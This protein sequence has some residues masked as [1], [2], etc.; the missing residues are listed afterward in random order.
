MN[1]CYL[2]ILFIYSLLEHQ[3]TKKL[4]F[5]SVQQIR[6]ILFNTDKLLLNISNL[7]NV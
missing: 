3:E 4:N 5:S 6:F 2:F 7:K 1:K